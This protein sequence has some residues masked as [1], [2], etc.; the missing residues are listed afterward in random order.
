MNGK[1]R[2]VARRCPDCRARPLAPHA[3]KGDPLTRRFR[4]RRDP[5]YDL[6]GNAWEWVAD[7]FDEDDDRRVL[8]GASWNAKDSVLFS[9][10]RFPASADGRGGNSFGFRMVLEPKE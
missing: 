2:F 1:I 6:G 8:R 3:R 5:S 7:R 4:F 9:S 10:Y